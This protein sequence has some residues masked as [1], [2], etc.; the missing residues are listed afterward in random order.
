MI[1]R[2]DLKI[3]MAGFFDYKI[4]EYQL[5]FALDC[6]GEFG[7]HPSIRVCGVFCRQSGKSE[8]VSKVAIIYARLLKR[9]DVLV[10][11]PTDRQTGLIA[12]KITS[13][14]GKMKDMFLTDFHIV[15]QTQRE[16]EFSNGIKIICDSVGDKGETIRG[17]TAGVVILE[18]AGSIKDSI[19]QEVIMPMAATTNAPIV[20]IGTPRG[21]NHF[22]ESSIDPN[23]KVHL[24]D[25]KHPIK[26]GLI[27]QTFIDE[28]KR[29]I[30]EMKFR[31]EYG[32]EFIEDMDAFFGYDLIEKCKDDNIYKLE[33]TRYYLG[34]DIA[35]LGQDS[36][37]LIIINV[38]INNVARVV[39][40]VELKKQTLDVVMQKIQELHTK[41]NFRRMFLDETGLGAG[42]T[43]MLAKIYNQPR[44]QQGA[45]MTG[46]P[47]QREFGDK[48]VGVRFT[49]QSK[50]DIFSN[51]KTLMEN[52]K[53]KYPSEPKLI[54]QLRD[55]RYELTE[56]NNIKLHHSEYGFD[57]YVDALALACKEVNVKP[58]GYAF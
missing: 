21:K 10:F 1:K 31:T 32:A 5:N 53:I 23:Y 40:C 56:A 2:Q 30:M 39:E 29:T 58:V 17:Y 7:H 9:G 3:Y 4:K 8:T 15:R 49:I 33:T 57:D 36:T 48:V 51:L 28:Q 6:L 27:T 44:I 18:E 19:V 45:S 37:C 41:Y 47:K 42:P 52:G 12:A 25:Y 54:A 43:D 35:R 20:K 50:L 14:L 55:F 24:Y 46:F 11:A 13:S 16:F 26:E 22:F 38:D 34:A